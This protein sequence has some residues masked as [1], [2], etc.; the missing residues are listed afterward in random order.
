MAQDGKGRQMSSRK[1]PNRELVVYVLG[2]LGG[3]FRPIHMED[4]A[5]KA[6]K[7]FPDAF[8]WTKYPKIPDKDIVR[9][10]LADARKQR[11]GALVNRKQVPD[12]WV[13]T[14][15][16]R[17]WFDKKEICLAKESSGRLFSDHRQAALRRLRRILNHQVFQK[18]V[19]EPE[20]F[21]PSLGEMASLVRCRVDAPEEVWE[22]RFESIG[23]DAS[24]SDRKELDDFITKCRRSYG[25]RK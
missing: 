18:Y 21:D 16:G 20:T 15:S 13:L 23:R 11:Y 6:H 14:A 25:V 9:V 17:K 12:G 10:A 5:L 4:I 3:S 7:L 2:E 8:S 19:Q 22:N 1:P 24:A